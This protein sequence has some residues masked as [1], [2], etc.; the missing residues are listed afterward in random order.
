M[1][2][3]TAFRAF[4]AALTNR[5]MAD[6]LKRVL[7]GEALAPAAAASPEQPAE[8]KPPQQAAAP[9]RDPALTLLATL[10]RESRFVDLVQEDLGQYSD[11][12]VGAAA[13]PCLKQC[14]ETLQ[15]L[16]AVAPLVDS[17]EGETIEVGPQS[18][19]ARYQWIGEGSSGRG[20]L[21]H[22]GWVAGKVELPEWTGDAADVRVI[23]PAQIQ[24]NG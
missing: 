6:A 9:A 24:S 19:P 12:Q 21:L 4:W 13:R 2:L 17:R 5:E 20:K 14:A 7:D 23:A 15:R 8:E 11:A 1:A 3:G 22:H 10:Q 18:S 16:M